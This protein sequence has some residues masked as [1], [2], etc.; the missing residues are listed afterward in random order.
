MN[1]PHDTN[2]PHEDGLDRT[3]ARPGRRSDASP[4]DATEGERTIRRR[5]DPGASEPDATIARPG[6]KQPR[7]SSRD[8]D[9]APSDGTRIRR[10]G[11][12]D[13]TRIRPR[14]PTSDDAGPEVEATIRRG[15]DKRSN[16]PLI[17]K[18]LGGCRIDEKLGEGGMGTVYRARQLD[19]D[20]D[21]AIKT[22]RPEHAA[23]EESL[24]RFQREARAV[25]K[26]RTQ[27]VVQV[28][29]VGNEQGVPFIVLEYL[30]GGSL[31]DY[32]ERQD[33]QRICADD[34][35][36][37]L[38]E[39]AL[40]LSDA[41][42]KGLVHRDIKPDNLLLDENDVVKIADF[43]IS[44]MVAQDVSMTLTVGGIIGTPMYMS[45]E[46]C[47]G[48]V[49]DFRSDMWS[50]GATF[51]YLLTGKPPA[52]GSSILELIQTKNKVR[53]LDP[54]KILPDEIPGPLSQIIRRLTML[55][56]A[57]RYASYDELLSDLDAA[58]AG[59]RVGG[60][61]LL[62]TLARWS[63]AFVVLGGGGYAGYHYRAEIGEAIDSLLQDQDKD[64][65]EV[66][67]AHEKALDG[68]EQKLQA[69]TD[70]SH[71]DKLDEELVELRE[72]IAA[73]QG[74]GENAAHAAD[75]AAVLVRLDGIRV[76]ALSQ[77][78]DRLESDPI[79]TRE[80]CETVAGSLDEVAL[81]L[82]E[83][84]KSGLESPIEDLEVRIGNRKAAV[85][86]RL[87]AIAIAEKKGAIARRLDEIATAVKADANL[88]AQIESLDGVL[89]D[90]DA[91]DDWTELRNRATALQLDARVRL[92]T[93]RVTEL[94]TDFEQGGPSSILTRLEALVSELEP[95]TQP[96]LAELKTRARRLD[97][98]ARNVAR[99]QLD[100]AAAPVISYP[101]E[102]IKTWIESIHGKA[103]I[104]KRDAKTPILAGSKEEKT[105]VAKWVDREIEDRLGDEELHGPI[106]KALAEKW[107]ECLAAKEA[108]TAKKAADPKHTIDVEPT[109]A[110]SSAL[111]RAIANLASLP[112][113]DANAF[114]PSEER[115]EIAEWITSNEGRKE[116]IERIRKAID[117]QRSTG[118]LARWGA[119]RDNADITRKSLAAKAEGDEEMGRL[120][121][122]LDATIGFWRAMAATAEGTLTDLATGRLGAAIRRLEFADLDEPPVP[123]LQIP[124]IDTLHEAVLAMDA[125]YEALLVRLEPETATRRLRDAQTEL[126]RLPE[127]IGNTASV[128]TRLDR[129]IERIGALA[130]V[131][132][133]MAP[134]VGGLARINTS[135]RNL[136]GDHD[137]TSFF[138]D[139][140]EV[141]RRDFLAALDANRLTTIPTSEL[142]ALKSRRS[143][144]TDFPDEPADGIS[145]VAAA[146]FLRSKDKDLPTYAEWWL[147]IKGAGQTTPFPWGS[148]FPNGNVEMRSSPT[149]VAGGRSQLQVGNKDLFHAI[150]NAAEWLADDMPGGNG[151][152][153]M[154]AGGGYGEPQ[155]ELIEAARG[156]VNRAS[157]V[158]PPPRNAGC[159]GVLRPQRFLG[160][161]AP[162]DRAYPRKE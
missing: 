59:R 160:D 111:T 51:F 98:D 20:R 132:Q 109:A 41:A 50:L 157:L 33:E 101:F 119:V 99:L 140:T 161:L 120:V 117:E 74:L 154:L 42:E 63:M 52:K 129:A 135:Q 65:S 151:Q 93:A 3:Q 80:H 87:G 96:E 19:L 15:K 6:G 84:P 54:S 113:F 137:V 143:Q 10:P 12:D 8:G 116:L 122:S 14:R 2:S 79:A 105:I 72:T 78:M 162:A 49:I 67:D 47:R 86:D 127:G 24:K 83:I 53:N 130:A 126:L 114:A 134:V 11:R 110:R 32:A 152:V 100:I 7:G 22:I 21:V 118:S 46:Q 128:R 95:K 25:G 61:K 40:A 36:R 5:P 138:I 155:A 150:G 89:E 136:A 142:T 159:R 88:A 58:D 147:A 103:A 94:E 9:T 43:G 66:L 158:Q 30:A 31:A 148:L 17:G 77:G 104:A 55:E 35:V 133:D 153:G 131:T 139:R 45:P 64:R 106:G 29:Q 38:R 56:P 68:F 92:F 121:E 44:K 156:H 125:G 112:D 70:Q 115:R 144:W 71:L 39:A 73:E 27:H 97:E 107:Q 62:A 13:G 108:E 75:Y 76:A 145:R 26:F 82:A 23:D 60:G 124:E 149:S 18:V 90:I 123:P 34:A 85:G 28:Y 91:G 102:A 48:D 141:S 69:S 16:D 57:A 4:G 81:R 1:D 37:F 146:D